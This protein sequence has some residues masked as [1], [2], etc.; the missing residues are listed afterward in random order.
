MRL[1]ALYH[2]PLKSGRGQATAA[3][4]VSP[5]GLALDRQW[6]VGTAD[7]Q[8]LSAR[9][10]P[11]LLLIDAQAD[12]QQITLTAPGLPPV[13]VRN[14]EFSEQVDCEVWGT[15]FS[16]WRGAEHGDRWLSRYLQRDVQ[17]YW[18]GA[19]PQRRVKHTSDV[20]LGFAD[21]YPLLIIGQGSLNAL[22][23]TIGR[24]LPMQRFRPNL[25]IAGSDPYAEDRWKRI[26][27]GEIDIELVKPCERCIM[28]TLDPMTAHPDPEQQPLRALSKLRRGEKGVIFGMNA[29]ARGHG[30]LQA[31][32]A[33]DILEYVD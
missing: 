5:Q 10:C 32:M 20:P 21:G 26:R 18:A 22:N 11:E 29:I 9:S 25:V 6:M 30:M 28:T 14:G 19:A 8:F 4:T 13:S 2:Y 7:G 27:I 3:T 16:G 15:R 31:G 17:L 12:A 1:S 23:D 33:V 24:K